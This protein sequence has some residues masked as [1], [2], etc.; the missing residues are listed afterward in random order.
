MA[1]ILHLQ[2]LKNKK[3]N[4]LENLNDNILASFGQL[5]DNFV[6]II[7]GK[8]GNGKSNFIMQFLREMARYGKVL[9]VSLEEG[10]EASFQN[11]AMRHMNGVD[12]GV[13]FTDHTM[14]FE[15]LFKTLAKKRSPKFVVIDSVQYWGI[16]YTHYKKLKERFPH[17]TFIFISHAQGKEPGGKTAND[18]R[19]DAGI[20]VYVE[21]Y[22]AFVVSR[23]QEGLSKPYVI[24]PEGSKNYWKRDYKKVLSG[25][26]NP[27]K[28]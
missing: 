27:F 14:T 24:W 2:Q 6:M 8:S 19:Y 3:Y 16:R 7:W 13:L 5:T 23:Y 21:G 12:S 22:V 4:Y 11:N 9:Y 25:N 1:K 15:E 28:Q 18:I 17:K 10:F 20:K 26:I